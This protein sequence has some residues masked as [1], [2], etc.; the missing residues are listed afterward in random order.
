MTYARR[1]SAEESKQASQKA[2]QILA[3]CEELHVVVDPIDWQNCG[4]RASVAVNRVEIAD[5]LSLSRQDT[6]S[7]LRLLQIKLLECAARATIPVYPAPRAL[8]WSPVEVIQPQS[9]LSLWVLTMETDERIAIA[10][11]LRNGRRVYELYTLERDDGQQLTTL[12]GPLQTGTYQLGN[13]VTIEERERKYTG[14]IIYIL[15]PGKAL[16]SRKNA[17]RGYNHTSG[18]ADTGDVSARYLVDCY[19]GFP[20]LVNHWQVSSER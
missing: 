9:F 2:Q 14:E 4:M 12:F 5:L 3:V 18:K 19:D 13:I 15:S 11:Y 1:N 7:I 8:V 10:E 6:A 20:H 16:I 17:M